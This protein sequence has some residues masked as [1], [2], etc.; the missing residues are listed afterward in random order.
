MARIVIV[1]QGFYGHVLPVL[2]TGVELRRRGHDVWFLCTEKYRSLVEEAGLRFRAI[3]LDKAPTNLIKETMEDILQ[4][5]RQISCDLIICDSAQSAPSYVAELCGIPW[6][7]F[8]TSVPL[9][10]WL[11][12]GDQASHRRLRYFYKKKLNKVRAAFDMPPLDDE[13]RTRG[14]F[15]GLS[16][17]LHLAMVYPIMVKEQAG[18]P[19][20]IRFVGPCSYEAARDGADGES[21]DTQPPLIL[22]CT[23]SLPR[24]DF[25]QMMDDYIAAAIQAF[26]GQDC[27]I[28]ITD[29]IRYGKSSVLPSNVEWMTRFPVHDQLM[30]HADVVITH[31]GC[32]T[33]QKAMRYGVP[34]VIVPLG[35]DHP[36]LAARCV[37]LGIAVIV[38]PH[39]M[40]AERLTQAVRQL[41]SEG[42]KER[43]RQL[44]AEINRL[45]PNLY[46]AD[47]VEQQL[48]SLG[49]SLRG[50]EQD[51]VERVGD[52]NRQK[53]Q[54][55]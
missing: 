47:L 8:H 48:A 2:G 12:P 1:S 14:D 44:A 30:P 52:G 42:Y 53:H 27:R 55:S 36:I 35:A 22:V 23:S 40:S 5:V 17:L 50:G 28:I 13:V 49:L 7:S 20:S 38:E 21:R 10:D 29:S 19:D 6:I 3:R 39:A 33:L 24:D 26:G 11:V 18:L 34:M 37:E 32:S 25:R 46:S 51:V 16:P 15:A 9:P 43:A 31:G 54:W 41:Q 4:V 45:S